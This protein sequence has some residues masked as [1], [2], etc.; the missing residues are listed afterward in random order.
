MM[1]KTLINSIQNGK[2]IFD[3]QST[4]ISSI[5]DINGNKIN[6]YTININAK[7]LTVIGEYEELYITYK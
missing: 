6:T 5:L 1:N 2:S 3:I 7:Q 4:D